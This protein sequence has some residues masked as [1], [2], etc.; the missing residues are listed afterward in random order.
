MSFFSKSKNLCGL[1]CLEVAV[2]RRASADV[3]GRQQSSEVEQWS[4]RGKH[5]AQGSWERNILFCRNL[6]DG[7]IFEAAYKPG[8]ALWPPWLSRREMFFPGALPSERESVALV[9]LL[10]CPWREA[11]SVLSIWLLVP[12]PGY[13]IQRILQLWIQFVVMVNSEVFAFRF[14]HISVCA[15]LFAIVSIYSLLKTSLFC[16]SFFGNRWV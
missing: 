16:F 13:H 12:A 8:P 11:T 14:S 15:G 5:L 3:C 7:R 6:K 2:C 10:P 9:N 1:S 4:L